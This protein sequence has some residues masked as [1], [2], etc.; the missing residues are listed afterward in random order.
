[1]ARLLRWFSDEGE[2]DL[3][4]AGVEFAARHDLAATPAHAGAQLQGPRD[5]AAAQSLGVGER[6]QADESDRADEQGELQVVYDTAVVD[7]EHD[8]ADAQTAQREGAKLGEEIRKQQEIDDQSGRGNLVRRVRLPERAHLYY[9]LVAFP[10]ELIFTI[11]LFNSYQG[12][13][14]G[15][16]RLELNLAWATAVT[17]SAILYASSAVAGIMW[18]R[19]AKGR[20]ARADLEARRLLVASILTGAILS[21][22]LSALRVEFAWTSYHQ[23]VGALADQGLA[24]GADLGEP[25]SVALFTTFL[26]VYLPLFAMSAIVAALSWDPIARELRR[27]LDGPMQ[28]YRAAVDAFLAAEAELRAI[29]REAT[30]RW[31]EAIDQDDRVWQRLQA[32]I[33]PYFTGLERGNGGPLPADWAAL[34]TTVVRGAPP[35]W[36]DHPPAEAPR[37]I[38]DERRTQLLRLVELSDLPPH[39]P[40]DRFGPDAG[41]ALDGTPVPVPAPDGP[42]PDG[43]RPL[44]DDGP[45]AAGPPVA[46]DDPEAPATPPRGPL[47]PPIVIADPPAEDEPETPVVPPAH[48]VDV[49]TPRPARAEGVMDLD[50]DPLGL[51]G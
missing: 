25:N 46:E 30:V 12:A 34:A 27:V 44:D 50:D 8:A 39:R 31:N 49:D 26:A 18:A 4:D 33:A 19:L 1:M 2:P 6:Y 16:G 13:T 20:S 17:M 45:I 42:T 21:V 23:A 41:P 7:L 35:R 15:L 43:P 37:L 10:G 9:S 47:R 38:A 40:A 3:H 28:A 22:A 51:A 14:V 29:W 48:P 32:A 36:R 11:L 24:T 5:Q